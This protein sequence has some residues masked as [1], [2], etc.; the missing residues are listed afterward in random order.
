M[1]K[2][3]VAKLHT[4]HEAQAPAAPVVPLSTA[5]PGEARQCVSVRVNV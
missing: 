5:N 1:L 4:V 2:E 3:G